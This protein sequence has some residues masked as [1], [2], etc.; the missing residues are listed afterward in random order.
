MR[1]RE[2]AGAAGR[3]PGAKAFFR[4]R[5]GARA[6]QHR[7]P[8]SVSLGALGVVYGDIGA[9]PLDALKECVH[10][11]HAA[12]ATD[13]NIAGLLSLMFWS[14]TLV[15]AVE[16]S[17]F[18]TRADNAG[19]GGI[20][21]LALLP[22]Q[23]RER[24]PGQARP[25]GGADPVRGGAAP[26]GRCDHAGD[27]RAVGAGGLHVATHALDH[28]V[29]PLTVAVL[30]GLF[31]AQKHGAERIGRIFGPVTL[32]WFGTLA[33]LGAIAIAR[34]PAVLGALGLRHGVALFPRERDALFRDPARA[35]GELG[36]QIDL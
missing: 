13:A 2:H 33:V 10:G 28:V 1:A 23:K 30:V 20:L 36:M 34:H 5:A 31:L 11:P 32:A 22:Q 26:W 21:L 35:R 12:A 14:V 27:E 3:R 8:E 16:Y 18:V 19:E 4:P 17:S 9:S 15:V 7:R 6:G 25:A 24:G 29:M